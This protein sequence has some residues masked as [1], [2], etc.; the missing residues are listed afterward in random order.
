VFATVGFL[1]WETKVKS[2]VLD[3]G[4]F[5][6]NTVFAFS[7]L[8]AFINYSATFAVTFILSL[9]LQSVKGMSAQEAGII[10]VA[11]PAVQAIFSPV[12]GRLSDK[13]EP[14]MLASMGMGFTTIG[15]GLLIFLTKDTS[16]VF[17]L[18]SL[19]ILGFGFAFFFFSKYKCSNEFR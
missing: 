16:L 10:L 8:A 11:M 14:R 4:L 2:P 6:T 19:V 3:V 1:W 17:I 12:A 13:I 7:N 5:R 18:T 15:L 9:Y